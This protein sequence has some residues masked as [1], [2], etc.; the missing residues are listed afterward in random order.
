MSNNL[1]EAEQ[2]LEAVSDNRVQIY[3]VLSGLCIAILTVILALPGAKLG[4]WVIGQLAVA[5]PTLMTLIPGLREAQLQRVDEF[6]IWN[7]FAWIT[8]SLGYIM[9]LNA[10]VLMLYR[11]NYS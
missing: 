11:N 4:N 7:T 3:N 1:A 10:T 9:I 2:R 5:V 8:H 6:R